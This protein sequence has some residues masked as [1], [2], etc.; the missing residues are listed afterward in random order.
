MVIT[1]GL[2]EVF[3][4]VNK[5][6]IDRLDDNTIWEKEPLESF[7]KDNELNAYKHH[8]FW[9]P[10]DTLR[11]KTILEKFWITNNAPWKTW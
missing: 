11:D 5:K 10:M 8:G 9:R 1:H 4:V 6:V 2:M 3:F 7:A